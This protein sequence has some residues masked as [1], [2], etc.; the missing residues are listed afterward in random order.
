MEPIKLEASAIRRILVCQLRQIGDVLLATPSIN[1]LRR[2]YPQAEIHVLTERKCVPMLDNNPD[3]HTVWA[4][5]KKQF[6]GLL[7]ELRWYRMVARQG[8]D[9]VVDFQQLPRTRWVVAFSDAPVKLSFTP[10]WYNRWLYT[11]W[12]KP[13]DGYAAMSKASVLEALGIRWNGERPRLY[14]TAEE[15][16]AARTL[17]G[18]L[19]VGEGRRLVTV[20]PTHRRITR[21]WLPE[22]Y[23]R[24]FDLAFERDPNIR[25]MPLWGPGEEDDI[26]AIQA[27]CSHPECLVLPER[28]L[29]L[30]EMAAC[31]AEADMHLGNCSAPR[32]IAVAVDTP[33]CI[34]LGA[35]GS[36]W[37]FPS[38][39]HRDIAAG[40]SCQ[41][42]NR[43]SC[44]HRRCLVDLKPE[45][46]FEMFYEHLNRYGKKHPSDGSRSGEA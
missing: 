17:L 32:H 15:R 31:I 23:A 5:D 24:L 20:D 18:E 45:A 35:T 22:H 3:V 21:C 6:K 8:F 13:R 19:G 37:T 42:C 39:E 46:V 12:V 41:P 34:V 40:L 9:I 26:K 44:E 28:M 30:R 33:S 11:H 10:P 27:A 14:L 7:D 2:T 38:P 1:L 29:S 4:L 16:Q 25:F 43:N 36:A